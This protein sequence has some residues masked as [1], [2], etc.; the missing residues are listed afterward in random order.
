MQRLVRLQGGQRLFKT[1]IP[2]M[3]TMEQKTLKSPASIAR[4]EGAILVKLTTK[5]IINLRDAKSVLGKDILFWDL[6]R[7]F[8]MSEAT[9]NQSTLWNPK[10]PHQEGPVKNTEA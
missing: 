6:Q 1:V 2:E 10:A 5:E 8:P 3:S 7:Y 4:G 9:K